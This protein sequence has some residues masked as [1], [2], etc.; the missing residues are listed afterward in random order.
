MVAGAGSGWGRCPA[1][2]SALGCTLGGGGGFRWEPGGERD[3]R[4]VYPTGR[5][6]I[7]GCFAEGGGGGCGVSRA[8]CAPLS[9]PLPDPTPGPLPDP[10]L[11]GPVGEA[12][13]QPSR[14]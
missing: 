14:V 11:P 3:G 12:S 8:L 1:L 6:L 9:F 2:S 4:V 5:S 13:E 7:P 10:S